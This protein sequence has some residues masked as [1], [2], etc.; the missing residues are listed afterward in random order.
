M[1]RAVA[2]IAAATALLIIGI[3]ASLAEPARSAPPAEWKGEALFDATTTR[4]ELMD[5][6]RAALNMKQHGL[7]EVYYQ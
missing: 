4:E 7:A 6:A 2:R 1:P 3:G 5:M